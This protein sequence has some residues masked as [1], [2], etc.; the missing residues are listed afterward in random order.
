MNINE[1]IFQ[2]DIID[3]MEQSYIDYA[4]SV[5]TGRALPD[6]RDGL[7][8]VHLRI[9]YA[10][11]EMGLVNNKG[12]KKSARVVGDVIGKYHPHGDSSVYD[13][14]V[15]MAQGFSMRYPLVEGQ[16]NFGT[17]DGDPAAAMRYTEAKMSKIAAEMI[18]D[19]KKD[20][21]DFRPNFSEDESEPVIL[22]A[23][24][25]NLLLNGTTG[26]A[27]GMACSFPSHH[28]GSTI[29]ALLK[30]IENE[31]STVEE[32]YEVIEGPDF[33]TGGLIINKNELLDGY[34]TGKGRV[35][36]RGKYIVE[37]NGK[38]RENLVFTEIP[39]AVN[40]EKLIGD[41]AKLCES[42]TIEGITDLRDESTQNGIRIV[43]ELG[44]GVN[45]DVIANMLFSKT[46]L[47]ETFS[48]NFTCLV[49]GEPRVL[50]LKDII[51]EYIK[52]QREVITRRTKF[53]LAKIEARIHILEGLLK[54]LEDIDNVIAII[55]AS[56]NSGEAREKLEIRYGFS[57]KQ[58]KAIL[59]MKLSKLTGL[60]KVEINNELQALNA[61]SEE[62][63]KILQFKSELD[64]V[65]TE[66]LL[67]IKAKYND[68]RRTEITHISVKKEEKEIQYVQ[69][70]EVVVVITKAGNIK[71]I[72][73]KSFRVQKSKGKGV[74]S[75]D[76]VIMDCI[77][78]NTIDTLM[79]FT[80]Y[81]KVYRLLVDNVP[82]GTNA[83]RG[84][85]LKTLIQLEGSEEPM[86]ITSL[87]RQTDAKFVVFVTKGGMVKKTKLEEYL[88]TKR[89]GIVGL[90]LKDG[91]SICDIT[92][93]NDEELLLIS[94]KGMGIRF[95]TDKI[96]AVGRAAIGVVG[97]TLKEGDEVVSALPINK[98]TDGV[99]VFTARGIAKQTPLVEYPLQ[100]RAGKGTITYKPTETTGDL[101][102]AALVDDTDTL[103]LL[104][105][106][107]TICIS[108]TEVPKLN[109][110][111]VGNI[112]VKD[113]KV[114]S[115]VKI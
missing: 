106:K 48:M 3:E 80:N 20:T 103:L 36:I 27:V 77:S 64:K 37:K 23:R 104:G 79:V 12:Y 17:I 66:E 62:L 68:K 43:I 93:L 100:N 96:G 4:M 41:I 86:A 115:V 82:S 13:A 21:V 19:L 24:I 83:S 22:P 84:V 40:K 94:K 67:E 109:K 78:T 45:P 18:R 81:G 101:V 61:E 59:D 74:K 55:K 73:A 76:D 14:M 26:I 57:D 54:A 71:K 102:G 58:S 70:E 65:L 34:K 42:K 87:Y 63:N 31:D 28:L 107:T 29:D 53:D 16:G 49:D 108:S 99:A 105:D 44:K 7:K 47:E 9:L 30:F 72:P 11:I 8:P 56:K 75:Q 95:G 6:V 91:D 88:N 111:A 110:V 50:S 69:P 92:F 32:L 52:H 85:A 10:M 60:E 114:I 113:N 2:V 90:K 33:P 15:R 89:S 46:Q 112:M 1:N 39:Y 98:L 25:P 38:T 51:R 35:R 97:M 5:I